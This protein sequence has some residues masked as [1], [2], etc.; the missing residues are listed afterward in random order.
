MKQVF[1]D[2]FFAFSIILFVTSIGGFAYVLFQV[3][4]LG[5][6]TGLATD[7]GQAS[8]E[9]SSSANLNFTTDTTDWGSGYVNTTADYAL[10]Y[11]NGTIINGTWANN[12]EFLVLANVGNVNVTLNFSADNNATTFIGGGSPLYQILVTNNETGSCETFTGFNSSYQDLNT[13]SSPC[14]SN[15]LWGTNNT[16]NLNI[17]L[18]IPS[19]APTGVKT[20]VITATGE[21]I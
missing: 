15:F 17:K 4:G 1:S 2:L 14:C 19:D 13:T 20:S 8:V 18:Q 3:G 11:T 16:L 21:V 6:L 12:T 5:N 10:L 9:I 7:T